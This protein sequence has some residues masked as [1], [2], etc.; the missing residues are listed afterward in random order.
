[1]LIDNHNRKI[2]YLR[3]AVTDR[4][5]L[6]CNYCMPAEGIDFSSKDNLFTLE[7]LSKLSGILVSQGIDK[8]RITGGEPF[9]RKDLMVLLR[10]LSKMEEL[11]DISITTNATL[12]GPFIDELKE[13]G[14]TNINVSMD[15]INRD[16]FD[17]ITRRDQY[18]TV[19]NNVLRLISEGFNVRINFIALDGQ[20]TDDI[21]PM[22]ELAKHYDVCVRYLEEMPFNGGSR[23]FQGITWDYKRI[24]AHIKEAYPDYVQQS[25][26]KTSTSMNYKIPGFKGTFGII[27]SFSRTF[28]GSCNRLRITATG[29][30]ITCLYAKASMNIRDIMRSKNAEDKIKEQILKAIGSR[31]KTGFEAQQK[32][33][34]VFTNSM[35]SIGG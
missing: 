4:C 8:I 26:E 29:D 6:R 3:L 32:D 5:N 13:L 24:L 18:E 2:N 7:E 27:P 34:G 19:Y 14:I 17:K 9:V 10:D 12:I 30:V 15:A 31:A 28:C 16:V 25:S 21:L 11:K 35:T 1:M 23:K 20:N 33:I 22:L